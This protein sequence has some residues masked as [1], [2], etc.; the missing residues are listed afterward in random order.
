MPYLV[1]G[2]AVLIG[3]LLAARWYV[4]AQPATLLKSLKWIFIILVVLVAGALIFT[5]RIGWGLLAIPAL[6]PLLM[7]AR[8]AA[9][10]AKN[11]S[12]MAASG[13]PGA[14]AGTG[15]GQASEIE[16]AYVRMILNHDNGEMNGDVIAGRFA[17]RTL[18]SMEL[19]EILQLLGEASAD[20]Q[21]VQVLSAYLDRYHGDEWREQAR[22]GGHAE[23]GG[24]SGGGQGG[25]TREEAYDILGLEAG[26]SDEDIKTAHHELMSK[27]HPDKG[28]S[29]Y[30]ATKINQAKDFLLGT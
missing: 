15:S 12:R 25:M 9:R 5:G 8:M 28:G 22:A 30:L 29:T 18:R 1:L 20:E 27:I 23:N 16:T 19:G 10:A 11:Y 13:A 14:G 21:S 3:T 17:G 26:A 4:S 6:L 2:V 7:R 24:G